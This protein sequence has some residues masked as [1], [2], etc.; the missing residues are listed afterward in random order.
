MQ[1]NTCQKSNFR[2]PNYV[3][4]KAATPIN[5]QFERTIF[6]P[7]SCVDLNI[8]ALFSE[9]VTFSILIKKGEVIIS[10]DNNR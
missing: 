4:S 10:D 5:S 7:K 8:L 1:T 3:L 2:L 6:T 9:C